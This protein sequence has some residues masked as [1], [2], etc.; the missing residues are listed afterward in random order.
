MQKHGCVNPKGI[1]RACVEKQHRLHA[2]FG[3]EPNERGEYLTYVD[4]GSNVLGVVHTDTVADW[5]M[6]W[7][8]KASYNKRVGMVNSIQLDDRLGVYVLTELLPS[9]GI[10]LDFLLTDCEEVGSS[11]AKDFATEKQY[12]WMVGFDRRGLDVVMYQYHDQ[13]WEK[14]IE[15]AGMSLARGSFS[16]IG[17]LGKLG[18]IGFNWGV[19]YYNEH[20]PKCHCFI[21]DVQYS[22]EC[23]ARFFEEWKDVY[24]PWEMKTTTGHSLFAGEEWWEDE[25]VWV[26]KS[27]EEYEERYGGK[28]IDSGNDED[29]YDMTELLSLDEVIEAEE[30]VED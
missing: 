3:G 5:R 13:A 29:V 20:T 14:P 30:G 24:L 23:F 28:D 2:R 8:P 15:D 18:I 6:F 9:M 11:T 25:Y 12:N 16:D 22:A 1:V 19:G 7:R 26:R 4:N 21:A 10:T 17:K 27:I